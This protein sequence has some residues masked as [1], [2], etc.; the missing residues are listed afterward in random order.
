MAKVVATSMNFHVVN[1]VNVKNGE[2]GEGCCRRRHANDTDAQ[3]SLVLPACS[4]AR[5]RSDQPV[6]V[7]IQLTL[8]VWSSDEVLTFRLSS[9]YVIFS[10]NFFNIILEFLQFYVNLINDC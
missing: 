6:V 1:K 7:A 10:R 5:L 4:T 2:T 3:T 9:Q 8:R